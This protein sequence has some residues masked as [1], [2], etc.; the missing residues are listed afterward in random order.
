MSESRLAELE[1]TI[2]DA[3]PGTHVTAEY[4]Y[5]PG[6]P[7]RAALAELVEIARRQERALREFPDDRLALELRHEAV[8]LIGRDARTVTAVEWR[9]VA[10]QLRDLLTLTMNV[11]SALAAPEQE[12]A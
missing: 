11:R 2:R 4:D 1:A 6:H 10:A 5:T 7:A 9:Q 3:L 8:R 12:P